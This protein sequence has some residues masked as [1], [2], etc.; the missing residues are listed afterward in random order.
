MFKP[1]APL[2]LTLAL[3]LA[4]HAV[5]PVAPLQPQPMKVET[6]KAGTGPQSS[7]CLKQTG[8]RLQQPNGGCSSLPGQAYDRDDLERTGSVT[9]GDALNRLSPS[10]RVSPH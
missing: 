10:V 4:V 9:V 3:P 1:F 2:L 8:T 7:D 6:A 5:E